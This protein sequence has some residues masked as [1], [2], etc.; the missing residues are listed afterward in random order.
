M[1]DLQ[2]TYRNPE[3]LSENPR[4][5]RTHRPQQ[6][7]QIARSITAFGFAIPVLIDEADQLIADHGRL[8]AAK[9]LGFERVPSSSFPA[10][11]ARKSAA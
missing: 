7:L 11:Q 3:G 10:Y 8:A 2:I 1:S 6:I 5:A 4:N 9:A